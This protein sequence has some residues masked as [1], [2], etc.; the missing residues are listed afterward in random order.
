M[1]DAFGWE[2]NFLKITALEKV[3]G[4]ELYFFLPSEVLFAEGLRKNPRPADCSSLECESVSSCR[5]PSG[6]QVGPP[7]TSFGNHKCGIN[8]GIQCHPGLQTEQMA[9]EV[10]WNTLAPLR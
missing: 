8:R 10:P 2:K 7:Q 3:H 4:L 5:S 6:L 9:R 1:D